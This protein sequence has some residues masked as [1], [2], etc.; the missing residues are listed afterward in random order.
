M[1][2]PVPRGFVRIMPCPACI[3]PLLMRLPS[4]A[5]PVTL[6]PAYQSHLPALLQNYTQATWPKHEPAWEDPLLKKKNNVRIEKKKNDVCKQA[7]RQ[8]DKRTD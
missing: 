7:G 6:K 2:V 8:M 3:P 4:F 5:M 1:M